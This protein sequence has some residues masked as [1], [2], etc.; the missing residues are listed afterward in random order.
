MVARG[1]IE[2]PTRGFSVHCSISPGAQEEAGGSRDNYFPNTE[3]LDEDEM[4]VIALGTDTPLFRRSQASAS[5]LVE[6]GSG[7]KFIF[8]IGTGSLC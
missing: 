7:E 8:D 4:R 3:L 5:W 2:P 6:L 1:G